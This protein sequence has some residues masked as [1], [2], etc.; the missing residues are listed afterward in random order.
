M[1]VR[2]CAETVVALL[3]PESGDSVQW[4][5]AGLLE[6]ADVIVIHK[7]DLPGADRLAADLREQPHTPGSP[8]VPLVSISAHDHVGLVRLLELLELRA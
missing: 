1:A 5:K 6:I 2:S 3:Q 7:S 4:E 8:P